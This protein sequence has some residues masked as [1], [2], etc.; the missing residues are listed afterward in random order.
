MFFQLFKSHELDSNLSVL[1]DN[2]FTIERSKI[3]YSVGTFKLLTRYIESVIP[4]YR[5]NSIE[6]AWNRALIFIYK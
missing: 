1:V 4:S 3:A 6:F 2:H 5:A